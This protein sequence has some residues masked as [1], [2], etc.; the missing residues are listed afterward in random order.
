MFSVWFMTYGAEGFLLRSLDGYG[1]VGTGLG[2]GTGAGTVQV[3]YGYGTGTIHGYGRYGTWVR[4]S[5]P[6]TVPTVP[7]PCTQIAAEI[8]ADLLLFLPLFGYMV[9]ISAAIWVHGTGTVG[10]VHGYGTWVR[11][12]YPCTVPT[13]PMY[14]TRTVPV[15]YPH[16][17]PHPNPYQP[18]RT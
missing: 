16:P 17:Y 2:A 13:V 8:V 15:P 12:S 4:F 11:F 14:R 3:R 6:C 9:R 5:Y 7:V 1:T 18:P 10:T